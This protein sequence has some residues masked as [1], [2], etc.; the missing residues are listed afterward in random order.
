MLVK[1]ESIKERSV[2]HFGHVGSLFSS[3]ERIVFIKNFWYHK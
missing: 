1:R 3:F 2:A